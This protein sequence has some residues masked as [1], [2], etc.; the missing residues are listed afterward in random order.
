MVNQT[1]EGCNKELIHYGTREVRGISPL[2]TDILLNVAMLRKTVDDNISMYYNRP[3]QHGMSSLLR[4]FTKD[5]PEVVF[6][7][8]GDIITPKFQHNAILRNII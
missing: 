5:N 8:M 4:E 6:I 1:C 2:F 7:R 3:R